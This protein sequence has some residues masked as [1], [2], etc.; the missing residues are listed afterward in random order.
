MIT[1]ASVIYDLFTWII[2]WFWIEYRT[3]IMTVT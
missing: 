2:C 1:L 3:F